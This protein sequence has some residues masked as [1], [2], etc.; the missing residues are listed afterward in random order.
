MSINSLRRH[1]P[2]QVQRSAPRA[3]S[4]RPTRTPVR[5]RPV[6]HLRGRSDRGGRARGPIRH[7]APLEVIV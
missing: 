1:D 3:L 4:A 2:D 5:T 7:L 6:C